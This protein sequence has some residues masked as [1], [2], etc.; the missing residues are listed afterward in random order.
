MLAVQPCLPVNLPIQTLQ[1]KVLIR[2]IAHLT[3]DQHVT[4]F[5]QSAAVG[6]RAEAL[7]LQDFING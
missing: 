6:A 1:I 4:G 7:L 3:I 5:D 2:V